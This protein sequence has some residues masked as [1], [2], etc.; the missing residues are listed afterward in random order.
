MQLSDLQRQIE[1]KDT[2]FAIHFHKNKYPNSIPGKFVIVGYAGLTS[3]VFRGEDLDSL[4][5]EMM[6]R[7]GVK[8]ESPAVELLDL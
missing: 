5:G 6:E 1:E 8:I 3:I 4:F 2:V 7:L